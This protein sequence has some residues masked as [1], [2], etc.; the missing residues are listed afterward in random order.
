MNKV[1]EARRGE[2]FEEAQQASLRNS[3]YY[4]ADRLHTNS[5]IGTG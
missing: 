3:G 5:S 1:V 4:E 2:I